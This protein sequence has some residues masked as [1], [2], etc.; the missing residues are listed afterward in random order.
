M[1]ARLRTGWVTHREYRREGPYFVL[2]FFVL[3]FWV[4][5]GVIFKSVLKSIFSINSAAGFRK[6]KH[7]H[8]STVR[9]IPS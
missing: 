1:Q 2:S 7:K 3:P 9:R 6:K 5:C 8:G 4:L